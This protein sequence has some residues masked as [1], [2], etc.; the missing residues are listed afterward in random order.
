MLRMKLCTLC[1]VHFSIYLYILRW[2]FFH[3]SI[4]CFAS[5]SPFWSIVCPLSAHCV[6]AIVALSLKYSFLITIV[7]SFRSSCI[8]FYH[9]YLTS[10]VCDL[11]FDRKE[12]IQCDLSAETAKPTYARH[13]VTKSIG[14][15]WVHIACKSW[16]IALAHPFLSVFFSIFTTLFLCSVLCMS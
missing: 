14:W 9:V 3:M 2:L 12:Y 16:K 7:H 10:W 6:Q 13:S 1:R 8:H 4:C 15:N 5:L 11:L